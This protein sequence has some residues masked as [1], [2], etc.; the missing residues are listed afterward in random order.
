MF[1]A[2]LPSSRNSI[3]ACICVSGICL[4]TRCLAVD[5]HVTVCCK[6][7]EKSLLWRQERNVYGNIKMNLREI[8]ND[9]VYRIEIGTTG[10]LLL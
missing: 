4:A 9:D 1:T 5:V 7:L 2:P 6:L 8:E 10:E 3:F